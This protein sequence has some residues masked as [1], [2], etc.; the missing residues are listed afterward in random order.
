MAHHYPPHTQA[1]A[2][3][4][5]PSY[6]SYPAAPFG[7]P[8]NFYASYP[9]GY[10]YDS[11][12]SGAPAYVPTAPEIPGVSARLASHA[13]RRLIS[14]EMRDA[15]FESAEAGAVRRLELEIGRASCRERVCLYV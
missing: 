4:A 13:L 9:A 2:Q 12:T 5:A 1:Q 6:A 10:A 15:G 11:T 8:S 3:P 14:S 7:Y